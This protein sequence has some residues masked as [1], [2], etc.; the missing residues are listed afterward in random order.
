MEDVFRSTSYEV[1]R[2]PLDLIPSHQCDKI[3]M[4]CIAT[5]SCAVRPT[6]HIHLVSSGNVFYLGILCWW[7]SIWKIRLYKLRLS[8]AEGRNSKIYISPSLS[9]PTLSSVKSQ[10]GYLLTHSQFN[11]LLKGATN[12]SIHLYIKSG[13][14]WNF[15]LSDI[16]M[17]HFQ[18]K[19]IVN[20]ENN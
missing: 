3:K 13:F 1:T 8:T 6:S 16:F 20:F 9:T 15:L 10:P 5:Q 4:L 18:A 17:V 14:L 7:Y 2:W 11:S 12:Y 19:L